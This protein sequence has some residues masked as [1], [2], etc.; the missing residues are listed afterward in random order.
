MSEGYSEAAGDT[1]LVQELLQRCFTV[2][3]RTLKSDDADAYRSARTV[4]TTRL[5]HLW[6][7]LQTAFMVAYKRFVN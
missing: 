2:F 7:I 5:K 6:F 3:S 1:T 4:L